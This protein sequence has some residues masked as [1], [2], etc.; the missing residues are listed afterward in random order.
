MIQYTKGEKF[1]ELIFLEEDFHEKIVTGY[2]STRKAVILCF[3]GRKFITRIS[4][5]KNGK[6]KSCGCLQKHKAK[7]RFLRH[8]LS[9]SPE[10]TAWEAMK[11]RCFNSK[12]K[13]YKNYGGR[14]IT[15]C[16]EWLDFRNFYADMGPKSDKKSSL[17]RI[18]NNKN[19]C[20]ENC[21]WASRYTQNRNRTNNVYLTYNGEKKILTDIA[22][23]TGVHAQTIKARISTGMTVEEAVNK[24]YKYIKSG[25]FTKK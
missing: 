18:D 3:C 7:I 17:E 4:G 22:R 8:N 25:K 9:N 5:L 6:C 12:R 20:K 13:Q 11:E 23:E 14:G 19:Y 15:V 2:Q 1:G 10:Y 21:I 16:K 24:S